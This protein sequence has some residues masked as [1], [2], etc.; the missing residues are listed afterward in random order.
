MASVNAETSPKMMGSEQESRQSPQRVAPMVRSM[1]QQAGAAAAQAVDQVRDYYRNSRTY[2][3]NH[4]E[5]GVI[6]AA[7][8]G[9]AVGCL[10]TL[11]LSRR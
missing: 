4:P 1:G 8:A 2:V 11:A 9:A 5:R 6:A 10:I 3:A 7:A